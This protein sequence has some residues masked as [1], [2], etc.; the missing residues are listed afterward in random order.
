MF[1]TNCINLTTWKYQSFAPWAIYSA[2]PKKWQQLNNLLTL[3]IIVNIIFCVAI[4]IFIN[5]VI[6]RF[7]EALKYKLNP[8]SF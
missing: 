7:Q 8:W 4:V 2:S 5:M 3:I 6:F 1:T